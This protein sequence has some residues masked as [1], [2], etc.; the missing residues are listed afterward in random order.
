MPKGMRFTFFS[1]CYTFEY[2][3]LISL[4]PKANP[5]TIKS[6][7]NRSLSTHHS[8]DGILVVSNRT[9]FLFGRKL[10]RGYWSII[11]CIM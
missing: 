10:Y 9:G 5:K 4:I 1:S 11:Y 3:N 2:D 6:K 7:Q 8:F